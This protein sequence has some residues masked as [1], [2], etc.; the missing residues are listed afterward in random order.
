MKFYIL[1]L[2]II[3]IFVSSSC[4]CE[5][6]E[7]SG[8]SSYSSS[9]VSRIGIKK[10]KFNITSQLMEN[11]QEWIF[12]QKLPLEMED[13]VAI[14]EKEI[15]YYDNSKELWL[16]SDIELSRFGE[17]NKWFYVIKFHKKQKENMSDLISDDYLMIPV[18]FNKQAIKGE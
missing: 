17:T 4:T 3:F 16:L 8:P 9:Y 7:V 18:L 12:G 13:A 11:S 6:Q 5:V 14:A 2:S 10:Y 15:L 1:F